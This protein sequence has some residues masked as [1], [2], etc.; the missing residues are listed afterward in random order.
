MESKE[1][2]PYF[3]EVMATPPVE[4]LRPEAMMSLLEE[5]YGNRMGAM[6]AG[7]GLHP[8]RLKPKR[9]TRLKRKTR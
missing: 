2:S 5:K 4:G 3:A 8:K 6:R 9:R 7:V 1:L